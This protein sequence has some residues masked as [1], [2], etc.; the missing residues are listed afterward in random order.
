MS[1]DIY[2]YTTVPDL[3]NVWYNDD[4]CKKLQR[5]F[6]FASNVPGTKPY[7]VSKRYKFNST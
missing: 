6:T 4:N 5:I 7:W 1:Q 2:T 3:K